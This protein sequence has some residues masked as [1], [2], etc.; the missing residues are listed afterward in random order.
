MAAYQC[1]LAGHQSM[2][3]PTNR[4]SSFRRRTTGPISTEDTPGEEAPP[5]SEAPHKYDATNRTQDPSRGAIT[6]DSA[7]PGAGPADPPTWLERSGGARLKSTQNGLARLT[8]WAFE[9]EFSPWRTP[10]SILIKFSFPSA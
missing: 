5:T 3:A 1:M 4:S 9:F 6:G 7:R 2:V 8:R 10:A